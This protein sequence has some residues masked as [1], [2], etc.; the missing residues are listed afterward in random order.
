MVNQLKF[1]L[2]V[3]MAVL[4]ALTAQIKFNVSIVPYTMQ[5]FAVVLSGLLLGP[6]YGFISQLIYIGMIAVGIPAGAGFKG[7]LGVLTGPTAGYILMFPAASA[8]CGFFRKFFWR[9]GSG[10]EKVML[11]A[12]SAVAF[13]PV[14][15][16]GFYVFYLFATR[17]SGYMSWSESAA[18]LF[19]FSGLS[20]VLTVFIATVVIFLPQDFFIDHVL[21]VAAFSYVHQMLKER[22]IEL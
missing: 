10:A 11:W 18:S 1:V 8:I 20:P 17:V 19:G 2:A 6:L 15:L 3:V 14:Y 7:G 13:I 4:T 22:G 16:V 12:G 9:N 21:A 5:N